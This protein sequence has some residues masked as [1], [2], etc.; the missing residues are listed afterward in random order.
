MLASRGGLSSIIVVQPLTG[1][2]N[3]W[4]TSTLSGQFA[5]SDPKLD[6]QSSATYVTQSGIVRRVIKIHHSITE[7]PALPP[8]ISSRG[9]ECKPGFAT[10]MPAIVTEGED[11]SLRAA[12][13]SFS[14]CCKWPV[15]C[16]AIL[17]TRSATVTSRCV[18]GWNADL[19]RSAAF[20]FRSNRKL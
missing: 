16:P 15:P 11:Y 20:R 19:E 14:I 13:F 4:F 1:A 10:G 17:C 6:T 2:V 18:S 8:A 7:T 12:A 5:G 9:F 3:C